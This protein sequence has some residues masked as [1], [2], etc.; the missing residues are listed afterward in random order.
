MQIDGASELLSA[1]R[2]D[3]N[4]ES[5]WEQFTPEQAAHAIT[6]M[7]QDR[8]ADARQR[9]Y[10]KNL[11]SSA[12]D[13]LAESNQQLIHYCNQAALLDFINKQ[14]ANDA[15]AAA[16]L[17]ERLA[18]AAE[19]STVSGGRLAMVNGVLDQQRSADGR[20]DTL[21]AFAE[22]GLISSSNEV[23]EKVL[24][25]PL[26]GQVRQ[27]VQHALHASLPERRTFASFHI[28][29]MPYNGNNQVPPPTPPAAAHGGSG[30]ERDHLSEEASR[31]ASLLRNTC[32]IHDG[33]QGNGNNESGPPSDI[34]IVRGGDTDDISDSLSLSMS[35]ITGVESKKSEASKKSVD[36]P[37]QSQ[38]DPPPAHP[39]S[40]GR[41]ASI[42]ENNTEVPME[43]Q[44]QQQT[45]TDNTPQDAANSQQATQWAAAGPSAAPQATS[46]SSSISVTTVDSNGSSVNRSK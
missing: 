30:G 34:H 44:Q 1:V 35:T 19:D 2:N 9:Q 27:I 24:D 31:M 6:L 10:S 20:A 33:S 28:G 7:F 8:G 26:S 32:N 18:R 11:A 37:G 40:H 22:K 13:S 41:L 46:G 45:S 3:P 43:Q 39:A 29:T 38:A 17:Y 14:R 21:A 25:L 12:K 42:S 36:P 4:S 16:D 15:R 5:S 23:L